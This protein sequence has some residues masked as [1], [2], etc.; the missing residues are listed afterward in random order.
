MKNILV[1]D[2]GNS[3]IKIGLFKEDDTLIN[4]YLLKT[5]TPCS[6]PFLN[7]LFTKNFFEYQVDCCVIGSV[8]PK[9]T[10]NFIK[11][12]NNIFNIRT[13]QISQKTKFSFDVSNI[14]REHVGDDILAL[15]EYCCHQGEDAIGVSFGTA[16]FAVYVENKVLKGAAIAPGI[17][18]SFSKLLK[19]A[20]MINVDKF[21]K[22][23][24]LLY[25]TDTNSSLEAGFNIHRTGFVMGFYKSVAKN[26]NTK[27]IISG[28]EAYNINV[29][30]NYTINENAILLGF[31]YIYE[32]NN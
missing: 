3:Y 30:F 10:K 5:D 9:Q 18:T 21:N 22:H 31:K 2:I 14:N 26:K 7:D 20:S 12:I 17:G 28:G 23:S 6:L 4:K 11:S 27:C 16:A 8:V 15:S 13:Y 25:G 1:I 32:L 19:K 24:H 29:D